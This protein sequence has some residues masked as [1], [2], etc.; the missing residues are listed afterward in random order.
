MFKEF[1]TAAAVRQRAR[2]EL[3]SSATPPK[4]AKPSPAVE[5]EIL[6]DEDVRRRIAAG[7]LVPMGGHVQ[8][9]PN[10]GVMKRLRA[11]AARPLRGRRGDD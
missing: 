2:G 5:L 1:Q 9:P 7:E 11:N 10:P 8:P 4:S 6:D 3:M